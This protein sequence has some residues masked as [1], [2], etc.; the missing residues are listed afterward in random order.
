M[1]ISIVILVDLLTLPAERLQPTM[2]F[3]ICKEVEAL[4]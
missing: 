2:D 4:S 3:E 1:Y